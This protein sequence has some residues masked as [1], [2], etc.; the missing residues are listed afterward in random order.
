MSVLINWITPQDLKLFCFWIVLQKIEVCWLGIHIIL[1]SIFYNI[2]TTNSQTNLNLPIPSLGG[3]SMQSEKYNVPS[4]CSALESGP[5]LPSWSDR[6]SMYLLACCIPN[7]SVLII[8]D[9]IHNIIIRLNITL[10][11]ES[12]TS[13][14][15]KIAKT[16][17]A[18]VIGFVWHQCFMKLRPNF[19]WGVSITCT[20]FILPRWV[21]EHTEVWVRGNMWSWS[22][23]DC[24]RICYILLNQQVF[25][26]ISFFHYWQN[27]FAG[28]IWPVDRSVET[29]GQKTMG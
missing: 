8:H 14:K 22:K 18:P 27:V 10:T 28:Q 26:E 20:L 11:Q 16:A 4:T 12:K 7:N 25:V 3:T 13:H 15:N 6:L 29:L 24:F 17:H 21:W 19:W 1:R 2:R 5:L 23:N 9:S